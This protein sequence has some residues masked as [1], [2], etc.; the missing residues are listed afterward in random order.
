MPGGLLNIV[1]YGDQNVFIHGNPTKTHFKTT[2]AKHTN[3]GLQKFRVDFDG[4]RTL[5]MDTETTFDFK[6][7]RYADLLMDTYLVVTMPHIWSPTVPPVGY[8][9]GDPATGTSTR[10]RPYEFKWIEN[11]GTQIIKELEI[12]VGSQ[13]IQ[14]YTGNYLHNMVNRDFSNTKRHLYDDMT[15]HTKEMYDPANSFERS[16]QYPTAFWGGEGSPPAEPSIRG[17]KLYIPINSWF[18]LS[19]KMAFPLV[20]LQ[21]NELHIRVTFRPVREMCVIRDI[22]S[23]PLDPSLPTLYTQPKHGVEEHRFNRFLHAPGSYDVLND[24]ATYGKPHATGWDTDIHLISTY[25]FLSEDEVAMFARNEQSYL[26]RSAYEQTFH[27]IVGP[28]KLEII[29]AGMV[30]SWMWFLR[31]NDA[32]ER[33]QWSNY[34]NWP[35]TY[36]PIDL[37]AAPQTVAD[38]FGGFG[39][40]IDVVQVVDGS[41]HANVLTNSY[42]TGPYRPNNRKYIIDTA[43]IIFDG[44]YRENEMDGAV[45]SYLDKYTRTSGCADNGL[46]CYNFCL[47]TSHTNHQPSGAINLSRFNTIELEVKTMIPPFSESSMY[48]QV[49]DPETGAIIGDNMT[50]EWKL[51]EYVYDLIF[52]EERFN[53]LKFV[54][55]NASLMYA[56]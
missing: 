15:G 52:M 47:D 48:T 16:G 35:Y 19:S 12:S 51:Y 17:R 41:V 54:S 14:Q 49:C 3:F 40:G 18:T 33:N 13:K 10:W 56:R 7:P 8:V 50:Q 32:Y 38:L 27:N 6:I 11:L 36:Q 1:A 45:Y 25:A 24:S 31:R 37:T 46:Y 29:T 53:I 30:S 20:S 26:I 39:P 44:K 5:N 2:Y 43:G 42:I 4:S 28:N 21:Y 23:T 55:G 34:T 22:R 9:E